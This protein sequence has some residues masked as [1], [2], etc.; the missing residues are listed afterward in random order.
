MR[1]RSKQA[2]TQKDICKMLDVSNCRK[3]RSLL[4]LSFSFSP[5]VIPVGVSY[6][7]DNMVIHTGTVSQC[8]CSH[9]LSHLEL[10]PLFL[11]Y[12][13]LYPYWLYF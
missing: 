12:I 1:E 4:L 7:E 9:P 3:V 13:Y 6:S 8:L 11:F 2:K 10:W 5:K